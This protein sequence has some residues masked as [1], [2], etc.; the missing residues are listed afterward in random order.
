VRT[1]ARPRQRCVFIVVAPPMFLE[2]VKRLYEYH[3]QATERVLRAA[4]ALS[5]PQFTSAVVPGQ[6]SLRDTLVHICATQ[7]IHL[8]WWDG[9]MSG[10]ESF[11]REF[12]SQGHPDI[13]AVREMWAEL[14]H[15]TQAFIGTLKGD[16]DLGRIYRR[17]RRDGRVQERQLWEMMLHV[18]NHGT[19]HRSEAALMLTALG[20]SP[21]DLD[22]L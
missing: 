12:R 10:D 8:S 9:T 16:A 11:R 1:R 20:H 18:L 17:T 15:D 5:P 2:A 22:L 14:L 21:G 19:Q 6:P 7:R 4:D 13:R 3:A